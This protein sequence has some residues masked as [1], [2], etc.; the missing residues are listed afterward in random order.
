[1]HASN[2]EYLIKCCALETE[3][4]FQGVVPRL[5]LGAEAQ[6]EDLRLDALKAEEADT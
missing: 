6:T 3:I 4:V 2:G 5:K 1:M